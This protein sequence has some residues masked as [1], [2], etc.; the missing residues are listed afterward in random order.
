[1]RGDVLLLLILCS[2]GILI[3]LTTMTTTT[4]DPTSAALESSTHQWRLWRWWRRTTLIPGVPR[5]EEKRR[6]VG[7]ETMNTT[8]IGYDYVEHKLRLGGSGG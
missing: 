3:H 5:R 2:D 6:H 1:M 4:L 8:V 7:G